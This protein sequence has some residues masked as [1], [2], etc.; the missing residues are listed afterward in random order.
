MPERLFTNA[1][2]KTSSLCGQRSW[3][4]PIGLTRLLVPAGCKV[5]PFPFR[6]RHWIVSATAPGVAP[7]QALQS[8]P[9]SI[10]DAMCLNRF[11]KIRRTGWRKS[12][13]RTGAANQG[14]E[15]R[16]RALV[17]VNKKTNQTEHQSARIEARFARRNHSSF[18]AR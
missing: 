12:T 3:T 6:H 7:R 10:G 1:G 5:A 13:A 9:G 18:S 15:R 14:E 17:N 2:T 8:Q 16:E 11:Q 4:P